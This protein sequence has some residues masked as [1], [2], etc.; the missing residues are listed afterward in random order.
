MNE[1]SRPLTDILSPDAIARI[2]AWIAKFPADRKRAAVLSALRIAQEEND[3][4]LS[5]P[6]MKA[7]AD[8]LEIPRIAVYE[9]ATF[10]TMFNLE[11]PGRH[12]VSLCT[13]VSCM[14]AGS[15]RLLQVF[16]EQYG[17]GPGETS[18]DGRITLK[19]VECMA[20]CGG[21][22]MC[23]V[24]RQYHENLTPDTLTTLLEGLD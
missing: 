20:A 17:I 16:R 23:E 21:A 22:P 3:N 6:V 10:Y 9:V 15:D 1:E 19:E 18:A 12:V 11:K 4:Y 2:D 7:V 13:N 14:L 24:G 5:E 8:Y